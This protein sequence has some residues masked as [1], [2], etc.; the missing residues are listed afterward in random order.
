[1]E[2][3]IRIPMPRRLVPHWMSP[4]QWH[5]SL[6]GQWTPRALLWTGM[7]WQTWTRM[8]EILQFSI[9]LSGTTRKLAPFAGIFS[10]LKTPMGRSLLLL[11][12]DQ[13]CSH[14]VPT[15]NIELSPR[16]TWVLEEFQPILL[17]WV[18]PRTWFP[19]EWIIQHWWVWRRIRFHSVGL[20][21]LSPLI[22]VV[23]MWFSIIWSGKQRLE[24]SKF[25]LTI[26]QARRFWHHLLTHFL[27]VSSH[28]G[29]R[30]TTRFVQRTESER[31][32]AAQS[33]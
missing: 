6:M 16:I 7:N 21:Y 15:S 14:Q 5:R 8:E 3:T 19:S 11:T 32:R 18:F 12:Q 20:L 1:M 30:K 9:N 13:Q 25:S 29:Q 17:F 27:Q 2:S 23:M 26:Q 10:L 24:T 28:Q 31:A 22:L 33:Q 4:H